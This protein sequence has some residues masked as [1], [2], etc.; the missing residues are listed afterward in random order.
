ML[1]LLMRHGIA[2]EREEFD[3]DDAERPLTRKGRDRVAEIA[4]MLEK[5]GVDPG[6]FVCSPRLRSRQTAEIA[7]E[8]LEK[9]GE[10]TVLNTLDFEGEWE[11]FVADISKLTE[12]DERP[13][14]LA[15]GHEPNIGQFITEALVNSH[16]GF[17]IRKGAV[18]ALSWPEEIETQG[19]DLRFYLTYSMVKHL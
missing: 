8:V 18:A 3:G 15:I 16:S 17:H 7:I 14:V 11:D 10:P 19:A 1:L 12:G 6:Y 5:L 4:A 2:V 13:T 9:K